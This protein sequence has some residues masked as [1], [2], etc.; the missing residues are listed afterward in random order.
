MLIYE[1]KVAGTSKQYTAIDEAIR[2]VQFVRN[3]CL[4][5]WMAFN[6]SLHTLHGLTQYPIKPLDTTHHITLSSDATA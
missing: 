4:R 6:K 5:K 1:Y 3:K 2:V